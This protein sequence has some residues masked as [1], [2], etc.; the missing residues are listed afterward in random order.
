M[1]IVFGKNFP[2]E[3][4]MIMFSDGST[5]V[6]EWEYK[7]SVYDSFV[8]CYNNFALAKLNNNNMYNF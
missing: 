6:P 1:T 3:A 5:M 7:G 4:P 8:E 2:Q